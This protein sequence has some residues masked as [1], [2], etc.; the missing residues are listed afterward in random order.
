MHH[1]RKSLSLKGIQK[2]RKK[3]TKNLS[4]SQETTKGTAS[5]HLTIITMNGNGLNSTTKKHKV[6]E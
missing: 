2:E 1:Y 4:N 5:P 6:V 3:G